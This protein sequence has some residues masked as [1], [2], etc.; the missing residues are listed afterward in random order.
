MNN[1]TPEN[2]SSGL[3]P[4]NENFSRGNGS[5]YGDY[6]NSSWADGTEDNWTYPGYDEGQIN[7][8]EYNLPD[9]SWN[10]EFSKDW[11]YSETESNQT[12]SS[13]EY[14]DLNSSETGESQENGSAN[15]SY[16]GQAGTE[17]AN[18]GS[19]EDQG[20]KMKDNNYFPDPNKS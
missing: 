4:D 11:S 15:D 10:D 3:Y 7:E 9:P 5:S 2:Q 12:G 17:S 13:G 14:D 19:T 1:L 8:T 18:T 20:N 16:P 6:N